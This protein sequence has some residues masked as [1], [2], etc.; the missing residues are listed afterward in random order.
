MSSDEL[1]F[2]LCLM[3]IPVSLRLPTCAG[4]SALIDGATQ[5]Q[6]SI[7]KTQQ[8]SHA[9]D[10]SSPGTT[11]VDVGGGVSYAEVIP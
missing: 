2:D 9:A 4:H 6:S 11:H 8:C 5:R 1:L 10:C 7:T 3:S